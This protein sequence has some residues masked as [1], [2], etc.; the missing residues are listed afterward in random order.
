MI[1]LAVITDGRLDCLE[2]AV[3]SLDAN[4]NGPVTRRLI[5]DDTGDPAHRDLLRA[6]Y[7][8]YELLWHPRGRQGF[9]GAVRYVWEHLRGCPEQFVFW[10]EDDF[11]YNRPVPLMRMVNTLDD[12]PH[13]S[14]LALRRQPWNDHERA[15]GGI[16]QQHP[17]A[18]EERHNALG[19]WWLEHRLFFTTNPSLF[20]ASLC[21]QDWPLGPDSE[22]RFTHTLLR[23]G[24]PGVEAEALRFGFWGSR[25]DGERVTHIGTERA[26]VGY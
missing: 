10:A 24:L 8:R 3:E 7:R 2:Q 6:K 25:D 17:D 13:L 19:S 15:A 21:E 11:T 5:Y 22:G 16:V 4:L 20:R 1:T 23:D 14:Q 9:G 18:Y 12:N 26:G